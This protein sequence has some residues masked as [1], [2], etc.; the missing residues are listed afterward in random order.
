MK[1]M[2]NKVEQPL[3]RR[4]VSSLEG[5]A[6]EPPMDGGCIA[7]EKELYPSMRLIASLQTRF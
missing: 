6:T 5:K 2:R 4:F 1:I 3:D 7:M